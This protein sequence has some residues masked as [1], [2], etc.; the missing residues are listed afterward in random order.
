MRR[1][2]FI[3]LLIIVPACQSND[4][5]EG[6]INDSQNSETGNESQEVEP[7]KKKPTVTLE[8]GNK[9]INY[10]IISECWAEN[11]S[12]GSV[13]PERVAG[14]INIKEETEDIKSTNVNSSEEIAIKINGVPPDQLG[15]MKQVGS[16]L[17]D[18]TVEDATFEVYK[19]GTHHFLLTARWYDENDSFQGSKTIGFVL[20]V[21][22]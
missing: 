11:C 22:E 10:K 21:S 20:E 15:Y 19:E 13:F 16:T 8:Q 9:E 1:V 3:L 2:I 17:T 12:E 4:N 18:A 5:E 7:L 14:G 6:N